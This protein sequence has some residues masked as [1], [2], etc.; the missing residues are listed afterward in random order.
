MVTITSSSSASF[1]NKQFP[2]V[3]VG[4]KESS[5][6]VNMCITGSIKDFKYSKVSFEEEKMVE[7]GILYSRDQVSDTLFIVGT[8]IPEGV[9][10]EILSWKSVTGK[11]YSYVIGYEGEN[12]VIHKVIEVK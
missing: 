10:S 6:F 1:C 3:S 4:S 5:D 9:P 7:R 12:G 2:I 11:E 8:Y